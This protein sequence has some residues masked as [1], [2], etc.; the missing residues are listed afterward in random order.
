MWLFGCLLALA[1]GGCFVKPGPPR[2]HPQGDG[3]MMVDDA[4]IM[5]DGAPA[6]NIA[7]VTYAPY[8]GT[9]SAGAIS[10]FCATQAMAGGLAGSYTAWMSWQGDDA[11]NRLRG[12]N[13]LD[14]YLPNGQ[15]FAHT[16]DDLLAL[17]HAL[18]LSID[19]FG[20]DVTKTGGVIDVATGTTASGVA[21]GGTSADC[22]MGNVEIGLAGATDGTWTEDGE[23]LCSANDLHV[24]C[25]GFGAGT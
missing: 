3:G 4:S 8:S 20:A 13:A 1:A 23:Q 18:P 11:A 19:Q 21:D 14:W 5:L 25:F 15:L 10:G 6:H 12:L 9:W 24:Y 2:A 16:V 17:P 7:F 22:F